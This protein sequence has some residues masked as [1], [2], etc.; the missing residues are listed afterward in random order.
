MLIT[1][2]FK[3]NDVVTI[4][5]ATAEEIVTRFV[6]EEGE[7]ITV[8][9]PLSFMMG[10]QGIGLVPFMFSAPKDVQC[11]INKNFVVCIIKTDDVVAKQY[12]SQTS[13]LKIV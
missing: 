9:K 5:T 2:P 8:S 13:G 4:K 6:S 11:T 7:A 12:L 1:T 10:P 3:A